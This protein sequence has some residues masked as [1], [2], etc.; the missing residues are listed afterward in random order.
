MIAGI[1]VIFDF[2]LQ[3]TIFVGALSLEQHRHK[4]ERYDLLFCC[5]K[6]QN[7]KPR[8]EELVRP[9]FQKYYVPILF[10]PVA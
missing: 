9:V 10:K 2:L 3:M 6:A 1:G 8:R 4:E 5:L 7:P